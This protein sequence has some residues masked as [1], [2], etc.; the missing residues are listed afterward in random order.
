MFEPRLT[1]PEPG[2][3]YYITRAR[4][5]CS[6]AIR[7]LPTDPDCDV[8]A[9]CVG[10]AVG[11]FHE[12]AGRTEFD[13]LD[14]V[15]AEELFGNARR[16]GLR[17]GSTPQPGALMIWAKGEPDDRSDG[18]GHAAVVEQIFDDGSLLT[19]ESGWGA[20]K[21]FWTVHRTQTGGEWRNGAGY[22]F[23]GFVYQPKRC[24]YGVPMQPVRRGD[25]G[26]PVKWLQYE[27]IAHGYLR[28]TEL[29]GDFGVITLGAVLAFQL[30][31]GLS[32]D[33]ICGPETRSALAEQ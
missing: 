7:G 1:R 17:T 20:E 24:P 23:L 3:R 22:R 5:G 9:N 25:S 31:H 13:L 12:I 10:Y 26:E 32:V 14:P 11:R 6:T 21:P 8:L 33:G 18:A 15:N 29:D 27:L 19:S 30:E 28:E 4:G 16:H 2:N